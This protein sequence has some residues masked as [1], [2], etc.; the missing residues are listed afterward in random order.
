MD[1]DTIPPELLHTLALDIF[2]NLDYQLDEALAK[3]HSDLREFRE[4][5][6]KTWRS[7]LRRLDGLLYICMEIVDETRKN[8]AKTSLCRTN[9]FNI[10]TRLHARCVQVGSEIS[11]LL[12]GGFADGAFARWRTLHETSVITKFLCEGDEELS[13]RFIDYQSVLRLKRAIHYNA[14][15]DLQFEAFTP[16]QIELFELERKQMLDRYE[17]A[18]AKAF[19]WANK[20]LGKLEKY[21]SETKLN[22][23]EDFVGLGYFRNHFGFANQYVHAGIDSIGFKLGTSMSGK[24]LLL[25]GPSN[26]GLLEP[27]QCTSLSLINATIALL[28]A[29]PD[30]EASV[31]TKVLWLWH[32]SLKDEVLKASEMLQAKGDAL[33]QKDSK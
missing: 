22:E 8:L 2:N 7:P 6:F 11:H 28:S 32:E 4:R 23:I 31:K 9:R 25:T 18:F 29:F 27:I 26:E 33:M 12:H 30:A 20:A 14:N 10:T 17:P 1:I 5:L 3:H 21:K 24:D 16:Q 19:G 15:N 13:T